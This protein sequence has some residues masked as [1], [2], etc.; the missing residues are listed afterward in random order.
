MHARVRQQHGEDRERGPPV[1]RVDVDDV[2]ED[3]EREGPELREEAEDG[4]VGEYFRQVGDEEHGDNVP[5]LRG[6]DEEV[7]FEGA[8]A[9]LLEGEG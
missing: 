3:Q 6:D 8:E 4:E 5:D 9:E 2:D 7:G 1:D